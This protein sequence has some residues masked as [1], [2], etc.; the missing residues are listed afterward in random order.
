MLL[1]L[2]AQNFSG[3]LVVKRPPREPEV[4][5]SIPRARHTTNVL[6]IVSDAAL[7]I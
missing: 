6:D 2:K 1:Q 4:V 5:R 7:S 3:G